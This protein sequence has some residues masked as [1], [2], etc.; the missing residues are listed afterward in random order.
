MKVYGKSMKYLYFAVRAPV[1][2]FEA[3]IG[4]YTKEEGGAMFKIA[5]DFYLLVV[6]RLRT[7]HF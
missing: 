4:V 5:A 2:S 6:S 7:T 1:L 3:P